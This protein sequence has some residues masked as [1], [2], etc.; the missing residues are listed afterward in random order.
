MTSRAGTANPLIY[1]A[2]VFHDPDDE[3]GWAVS[4]S[5]A[6]AEVL[7]FNGH[8]VPAEMG[9]RPGLRWIEYDDAGRPILEDWPDEHVN[10][11]LHDGA[12]TP[13]D[14]KRAGVILARYCNLLRAA[15]RSY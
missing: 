5:F 15:G 12:V 8:D 6:V 3:W 10:E 2:R 11:L 1:D 13:D 7:H 4:W 14:L 9:Y